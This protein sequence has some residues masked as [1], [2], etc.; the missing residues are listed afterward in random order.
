MTKKEIKKSTERLV[1]NAEKGARQVKKPKTG[2]KVV[3]VKPKK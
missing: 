2:P 3:V 1:Q